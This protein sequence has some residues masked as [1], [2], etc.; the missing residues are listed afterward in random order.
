MHK[1]EC[2]LIPAASSDNT[3]SL[4]EMSTDK[5]VDTD[6]CLFP[7]Q[8]SYTHTHTHTYMHIHRHTKTHIRTRMHRHIDVSISYYTH[9]L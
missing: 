7:T 2:Q 9:S 6:R 8:H 1:T 3:V 4:A 5:A